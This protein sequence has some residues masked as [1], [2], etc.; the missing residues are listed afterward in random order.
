M[1]NLS[2]PAPAFSNAEALAIAKEHFGVEGR[3]SSLASERDQNF[4]I[5]ASDGSIWILKAVN[6]SE[7][8]PVAG[9]AGAGADPIPDR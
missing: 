7:I 1:I 9:R 2:H 5:D 6:S 4:R 8:A 3:I